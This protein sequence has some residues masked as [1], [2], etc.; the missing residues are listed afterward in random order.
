MIN[1][2]AFRKMKKDAM[3]LNAARGPIVVEEDL[4]RALEE[5]EIAAA[6]LD[7]FEVEPLPKESRLWDLPNVFLTTHK[8]GA[9]DSWVKRLKQLYEENMAAYKEGKPL[10]NVIHYK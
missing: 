1:Y 3:F 2:D 7:V 5:G 6:A 8:A 9:G 10:R 4:I